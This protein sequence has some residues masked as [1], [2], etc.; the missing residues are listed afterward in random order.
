MFVGFLKIIVAGFELFENA[1]IAETRYLHKNYASCS[2]TMR[3][4]KSLLT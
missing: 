3:T 2:D 4:K 1:T